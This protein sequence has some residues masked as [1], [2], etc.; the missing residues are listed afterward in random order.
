MVKNVKME[1]QTCFKLYQDMGL[2]HW[3]CSTWLC[4]LRLLRRLTMK[5]CPCFTWAVFAGSSAGGRKTGVG[6]AGWGRWAETCSGT[7]SKAPTGS[8]VWNSCNESTHT[9]GPQKMA[10]RSTSLNLKTLCT[11]FAWLPSLSVVF[12]SSEILMLSSSSYYFFLD[13]SLV[14]KIGTTSWLINY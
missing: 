5:T 12:W 2:W 6:C 11:L 3:L 14:F 4:F 8:V 13:E 1:F 10:F 9:T 7:W